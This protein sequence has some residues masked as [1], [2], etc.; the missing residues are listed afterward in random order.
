MQFAQLKRRELMTLAGLVAAWPLAGRAQQSVTPVI[1]YLNFGSP[2]PLTRTVT[3]AFQRGL[4]ELGF[5]EGRNIAIEYRWAD[6]HFERLPELAA[7]LV[8]RHVD[9][10]AAVGS[11]SPGLAAKAATSTIP[12]VFQTGADPVVDGLVA[13]MNRPGGN[14]TG[15]SRMTVALDPKR[16]ELLHEAVPRATVV[17]LLVNQ[18]TP[19]AVEVEQVQSAAQS[20]GVTV[21]TAKFGAESELEGAFAAMA[22][23]Q[24]GALLVGRDP[25]LGWLKKIA[26]MTMHHAIPGMSGQRPYVAAGGLMSYDA[27]LIDSFRQVGV[28]VGQVLKGKK[29]ADLPVMQP[30]KFELVINMK[31]ARALGLEVP[32]MLLA[33]ADEVIE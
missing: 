2:G 11:S 12:I 18:D 5:I 19:R 10:I 33:R 9:V 4:S 26:A 6:G 25:T 30:T 31:T 16:L 13:S 28:Y 14:V 17:A 23:Q 27:S 1:G 32:P 15:V 20:L 29:P 7:D 24:V 21:V 3:S 22:R 8:R